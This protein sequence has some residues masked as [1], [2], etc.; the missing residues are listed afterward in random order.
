MGWNRGRHWDTTTINK[1][2]AIEKN[3][4]KEDEQ[5]QIQED[6]KQAKYLK[7]N[8]EDHRKELLVVLKEHEYAFV[9]TRGRWNRK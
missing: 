1:F 5:I 4:V 7:A 3:V 6:I 8:L 9:G 2:W